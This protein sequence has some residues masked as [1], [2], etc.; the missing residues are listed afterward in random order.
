MLKFIRN[1]V[2]FIIAAMIAGEVVVRITH[3][4][5]D[6]PQRII[7]GDG[8]QKYY[9]NQTG[10][11]LNGEHTWL[12]NEL[13]WPGE[14]PKSYD[15]LVLIIG[16]SFVENFMN[17]NECHQAPLL[18]D[19]VNEY[20]FLETARSG[21]SFIEAF[22]IAKQMD[23][24]NPVKSL[25]YINDSD[26]YESVKEISEKQDITQL[27]ISKSR[28]IHGKMKSPG[29]KKVL[30]NWKLIYYFY[31]RFPLNFE[32]KKPP[33][34]YVPKERTLKHANEVDGLLNYIKTKY[35]ITDKILVFHPYSSKKLITKCEEAGFKVISLDSSNDSNSW[36]FD[37]D[38]HWTCYGHEQVANQVARSLKSSH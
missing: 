28:V 19:R 23:T 6:V 1:I 12:I 4:V 30:Y 3:A 27:D 7:D 34:K 36:T 13:G 32:S 29:I 15:N 10:Y 33:K 20:S 22:E 31:N 9:P 16:D 25:L 17:P 38:H 5:S 26:F 8:I 21:V 18:E 11:S 35:R 37:F 24:L 14:L 2:L